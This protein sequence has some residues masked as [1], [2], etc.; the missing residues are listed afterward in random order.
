M[1]R[2]KKLE[3]FRKEYAKLLNRVKISDVNGTTPTIPDLYQITDSDFLKV[4]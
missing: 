1:S 2:S 3:E 4:N